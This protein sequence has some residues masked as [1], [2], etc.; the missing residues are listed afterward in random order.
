ME[1]DCG[2]PYPKL[3]HSFRHPHLKRR[4]L[5][6]I[7]VPRPGSTFGQ[8]GAELRRRVDS[9]VKGNVPSRNTLLLVGA[10]PNHLGDIALTGE[11]TDDGTNSSSGDENCDAFSDSVEVDSSEVGPHFHIV[12]DC[13]FI[14]SR[15]CCAI[16]KDLLHGIYLRRHPRHNHLSHGVSAKQFWNLLLY[17]GVSGRRTLIRIVVGR[18]VFGINKE[19]GRY[20]RANV[21]S[22]LKRHKRAVEAYESQ[23]SLAAPYLENP[24]PSYASRKRRHATGSLAGG[25]RTEKVGDQYD[26]SESALQD[27]GK[28]VC[29]DIVEEGFQTIESIHGEYEHVGREWS[30]IREPGRPPIGPRALVNTPNFF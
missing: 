13:N 1:L 5:H 17:L 4:V 16:R 22:F 6:D 25:S 20:D 28:R 18:T 23:R 11:D 3:V 12:H 24:G 8:L 14:Q 30:A 19:T 10:H 29:Q 7:A 21:V 27:A 15:C 26:S 9:L 2:P